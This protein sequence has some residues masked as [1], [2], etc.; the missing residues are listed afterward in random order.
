M[1]SFGSFQTSL[2]TAF[3]WVKLLVTTQINRLTLKFNPLIEK[4]TG[5][6]GVTDS[7]AEL[8]DAIVERIPKLDKILDWSIK[9]I[10]FLDSIIDLLNTTISKLSQVHGEAGAFAPKR[11]PWGTS[12]PGQQQG[13][14]IPRTGMRMLH[15]GETVLPAGNMTINFMPTITVSATSDVDIDKL[16]DRLSNDLFN[17]VTDLI[18]R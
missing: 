1:I 13:G 14:F 8:S 2:A 18:R 4:L 3:D 12:L 10:D 16:N 15:A 9:F 11:T 7:I 5:E 17:Q 6:G